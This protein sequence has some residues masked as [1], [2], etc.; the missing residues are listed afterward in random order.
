MADLRVNINGIE[1]K[2]PIIGASGTFG[3]GLEFEDYLDL[4][5]VGGI[6]VKGLTLKR[7]LGNPPPRIAE[8]PSGVLNSVGLQNPGVDVFLKEYLPK[9]VKYDIRVIANI[10]GNTLDEYCELADKLKGSSIDIYELNISC[11]NVKHGGLAF[12]AKPEMVYDVTREV[13]K[14][15]DKPLMVKLTPNTMDIKETAK[16]AEEGG[17][18]SISLINTLLGMAIDVDLRKPVLANITGGLSGPAIMPVALRMVWQAAG[19]VDIPVVGMGGIM[20]GRDAAAFLMAG[21]KA[22]S[23][24]TASLVSPDACT[25]IIDELNY[26]MDEK[27]IKSI[28]ELI[29]SLIVD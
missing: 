20:T 16:A 21:A 14:H 6:S 9:L 2:N 24:G 4:N 26:F 17:A 7:R 8:T 18:D 5:K 10:N 19:A 11:P 3:F 28:D 23:V 22:V 29:D 13:K 12:G 27:E 25:R 1:F 15:C